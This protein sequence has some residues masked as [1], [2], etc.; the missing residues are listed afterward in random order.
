MNRITETKNLLALTMVATF[1]AIFMIPVGLANASHEEPS[2]GT[3]QKTV[4]CPEL[5]QFQQA[6]C[7]VNV[8]WTSDDAIADLVVETIPAGFGVTDAS[9][10][11]LEDAD[12]TVKPSRLGWAILSAKA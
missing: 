8:Q 12:C 9:K 4:N 11:T 10:E 7:S 2:F 6:N 5:V 1:A 3:L